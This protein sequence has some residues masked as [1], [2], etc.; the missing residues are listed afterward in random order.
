VLVELHELG[1]RRDRP[2][3]VDTAL[4][5]TEHAA[6]CRAEAYALLFG[7]PTLERVAERAALRGQVGAL[8]VRAANALVAARSGSALLATSPE[9]RWVREAAFHLIQAQTAGV[10]AAQLAALTATP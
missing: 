6:T 4:T 10:R 3:A 2:D 1:V 5:L 7:V 9:Q 8:L